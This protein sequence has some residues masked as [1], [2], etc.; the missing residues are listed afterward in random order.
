MRKR[1]HAR[2]YGLVQGVFFRA[3]TRERAIELGI[4][5]W[6][7]NR[8]DGSVEVLAEGEEE[9]LK[10]LLDWLHRGPSGARVERV[11]YE[12]GDAKNEFES[13]VIKYD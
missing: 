8:E 13:F 3:N 11:D 7:K 1:L 5:G 10:K 4:V 12:W 6:V 9:A 2:I